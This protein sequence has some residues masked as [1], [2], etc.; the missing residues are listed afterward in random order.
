MLLGSGAYSTFDMSISATTNLP[1]VRFQVSSSS[2]TALQGVLSLY[3]GPFFIN[4]S[5]TSTGLITANNGLTVNNSGSSIVNFSN[6]VDIFGNGCLNLWNSGNYFQILNNGSNVAFNSNYSVINIAPTLSCNSVNVNGDLTLKNNSTINKVVVFSDVSTQHVLS[7]PLPRYVMS[8][9]TSTGTL[10]YILP[11]ITGS[12]DGVEIT[13]RKTGS[14][15]LQIYIYSVS[16]TT[17]TNNIYGIGGYS[18]QTLIV[19]GTGD[20]TPLKL[21]ACAG[22][23][24]QV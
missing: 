12:N 24:Y 20:P 3:S 14:A 18:P 15:S 22:A 2:G 19:N 8:S 13:F 11:A 1:D 7:F 21:V 4:S 16:S 6:Q 17:P 23:W 5:V 10:T 9:Y